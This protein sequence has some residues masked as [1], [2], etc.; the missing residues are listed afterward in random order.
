[1]KSVE[2]PSEVNGLTSAVQQAIQQPRSIAD[3][4]AALA[5]EFEIKT[6]VHAL[7][8]MQELAHQVALQTGDKALCLWVDRIRDEGYFPQPEDIQTMDYCLSALAQGRSLTTSAVSAS[9][10][11]REASN[12]MLR[13]VRDLYDLC[14]EAMESAGYVPPCVDVKP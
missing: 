4:D 14:G 11:I 8:A 2:T 3:L 6:A 10:A 9:A 1:M 13:A 5:F 7:H 12:Q